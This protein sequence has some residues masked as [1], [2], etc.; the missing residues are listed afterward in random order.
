MK[1][2]QLKEKWR[3]YGQERVFNYT[4]VKDRIADRFPVIR[5][6][7]N[8]PIVMRGDFPE[9]I[10]FILSGIAIGTRDYEDGNEYDYFQ[11]DKANGSVGLLEVLAQKE[12]VV[13]T[14][15]ALTKMEV[16]R[17]PAAEVY[18]WIMND[19]ELLRLSANLLADDLYRRSGNDGL[20]Y[21]LEGVERL[22]YYLSTY[23]ADHF[24][25]NPLVEVKESREKIGNK[26]GMSLRTVGRSLKKLR[27]NGEIIS[28][29]RKT[30]IG[31]D[32]YQRLKE[33]L[34]HI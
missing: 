16:V 2:N 26:L 9:Y 8:D 34:K 6:E 1:T 14:I 7:P 27:D 30:Y 17:V 3:R 24:D 31:I 29:Q 25:G 13:A 22:R 28:K 32:E 15:T 4:I 19:L 18:E 5:Y 23:Y 21:R 20:L 11:L 10:Y 33:K 12:E